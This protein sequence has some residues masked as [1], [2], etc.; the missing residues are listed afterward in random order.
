MQ[1]QVVG[2]EIQS[3]YY[4]VLDKRV[5]ARIPP[6]AILLS[7]C[8]LL[9]I[10]GVQKVPHWFLQSRKRNYDIVKQFG[11]QADICRRLD[12]GKSISNLVERRKKDSKLLRCTLGVD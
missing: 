10:N 11:F 5:L 9:E 1:L 2:G 7:F 4:I 8:G 3:Y 6:H 12:G